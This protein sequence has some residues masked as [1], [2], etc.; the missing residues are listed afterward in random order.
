MTTPS[1]MP[2][3]TPKANPLIVLLNVNSACCMIGP[4]FSMNAV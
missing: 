2:N 3:T 4:R 1:A